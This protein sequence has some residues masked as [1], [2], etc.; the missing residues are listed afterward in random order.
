MAQSDPADIPL[1]EPLTAAE[2]GTFTHYSVVERLPEIARRTINENRFPAQVEESIYTLIE[3]IPHGPIRQLTDRQAPDAFDWRRY[4]EGYEGQNWLHVPWFFAETYFYRRLLEATGYFREGPLG[5][6]DPFDSQ[7]RQGLETTRP[8]LAELARELAGWLEPGAWSREDFLQVLRIALW[9]NQADLSL[10]P[11]GDDE[12]PVGAGEDAAGSRLIADDS[13][14]V[15]DYLAARQGEPARVDMI[16]DNAGFELV[17]DLALLDYL[18]T[19]GAAHVVTLHLKA[20]PTFVSD[21]MSKDAHD[22]VEFLLLEDDD[23]VRAFG[24]RLREHL[25]AGRLRLQEDFYWNSPL[26]LWALPRLMQD[27]FNSSDLVI[28]KG[29]ANY[30]RLLGDRHWP[31]TVG[32]AEVAGYFLPPLLALRTCKSEVAVGLRAGQAP[33]LTQRDPDWLINGEWG[34]VQFKPRSGGLSRE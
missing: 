30:R 26:A 20:H 3:S 34:M 32:F 16:G 28:S 2:V 27:E 23:A 10:W 5:G 13:G 18:L 33:A 9:G 22:T 1:P 6:V 12:Q 14:A 31:F 21:A 19:T 17:T 4:I 11:A 25:D 7:K 15:A 24:K 8:G 29:D